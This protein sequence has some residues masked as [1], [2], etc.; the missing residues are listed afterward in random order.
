IWEEAGRADFE[1]LLRALTALG[2]V[3]Y[4][5]PR[6]EADEAIAALVHRLADDADVVIR[7]DDKDFMQL[8]S[9][10]VRMR[11][12]RRGEVL[13]S[14]VEAI[15]GVTPEYAADW[16]A[17]TGD[18]VDGI[19]RIVPPAKAVRLIGRLGHVREWLDGELPPDEPLRRTLD[20]GRE[21]VRLNLELV[22]LSREAVEAAGGPGEP[23]L[24]GWGDLDVARA[25][26][27]E[28]GVSWLGADDLETAWAALR[29]GGRR[30]RERLG[31]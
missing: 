28:T 13:H 9:S 18:P 2:A 6:L 7:S 19:P 25:I 5:S 31:I 22:D 21:Q 15:L 1:T 10:R 27:E 23:L 20:E 8:L 3:Q 17:L 26:G 16:Q 12:R 4:R 29:E 30:M 14:D 24:E 11:G